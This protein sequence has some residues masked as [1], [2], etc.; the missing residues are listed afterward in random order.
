[1]SRQFTGRDP[2]VASRRFWVRASTLRWTALPIGS[3]SSYCA[4][5]ISEMC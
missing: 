1:M 3:A 5:N 4:A 2:G